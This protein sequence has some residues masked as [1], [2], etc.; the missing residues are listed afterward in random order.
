M[1]RHFLVCNNTF[2]IASSLGRLNLDSLDLSDN[3]PAFLESR[4]DEFIEQILIDFFC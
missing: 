1:F 4:I 2:Q 3:G